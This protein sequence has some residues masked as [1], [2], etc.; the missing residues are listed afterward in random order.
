MIFRGATVVDGSAAAAF[1]ADV[2]VSGDRITAVGTDLS[3]GPVVDV[4]GLVLAP[5]FVDMHAH[6][7]LALFT[8]PAHLAKVSQGI[9]C[10]VLG[11]DGVSYAP[12]DGSTLPLIRQQIA[13]WN[14][15][16]PG[17]DWSWRPV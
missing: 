9:T 4:D 6:S 2:A 16:P 3:G 11:Q 10:E 17:F 1:R 7:D 5:G 13:G 8:D 12:V 15:D 14:G